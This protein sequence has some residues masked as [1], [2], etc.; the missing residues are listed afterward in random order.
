MRIRERTVRDYPARPTAPPPPL[1]PSYSTPKD[2]AV[3][4]SIQAPNAIH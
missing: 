1:P 2:P 3:V 4:W